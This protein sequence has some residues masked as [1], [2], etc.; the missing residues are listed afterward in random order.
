MIYK[1]KRIK[2]HK[3]ALIMATAMAIFMLI[4]FLPFTGVFA[5]LDIGNSGNRG[6]IFS[7]FFLLAPVIYFVF[8][9]ITMRIMIFI[10]N[11]LAKRMSGITLELETSDVT[12]AGEQEEAGQATLS[13]A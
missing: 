13:E 6:S 11:L 7:W 10:Y 2:G 12:A 8:G 5:L 4:A 9:Y 3:T 1:V